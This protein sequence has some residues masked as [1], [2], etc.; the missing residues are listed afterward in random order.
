[1]SIHSYINEVK[2]KDA[3]LNSPKTI[4]ALTETHRIMKKIDKIQKAIKH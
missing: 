1:M 3:M 2:G 4:D